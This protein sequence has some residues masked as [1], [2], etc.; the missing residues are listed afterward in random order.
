MLTCKQVAKHLRDN[1][2]KKLS[3]FK[4]ISLRLHVVFCFVCGRYQ[5]QVMR[6]QDGVRNYMGK[7][8]SRKSPVQKDLALN[9]D[10]RSSIAN[11]ISEACKHHDHHQDDNTSKNS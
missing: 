3:F 6:F 4:R 11:A 8:S 9:Q 1:D 7:E 2:Y 10:D 5:R